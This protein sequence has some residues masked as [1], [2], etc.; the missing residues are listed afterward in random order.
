VAVHPGPVITRF[1]MQL[2]PGI[3]ASRITG[4]SQD[5]A[6]SMSLVS[7]RVVEV[8]AGRS[9][10]GIE[11]PNDHRE[12]V[13]LTE[14]LQSNQYIEKQSPLT[15]ALGKDISGQSSSSGCGYHGIG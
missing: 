6:R 11:V 5:I 10:I 4:L 7:V 8:I 13:Q 14:L 12:I 2:A 9:T 1:E 3:K 15:L